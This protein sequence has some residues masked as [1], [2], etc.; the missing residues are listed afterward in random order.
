MFF[1]VFLRMLSAIASKSGAAFFFGFLV[2]SF[3]SVNWYDY[4]RLINNLS[5][6]FIQLVYSI[7]GI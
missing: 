2:A 1:E 7:L 5:V 3:V 6:W 4:A